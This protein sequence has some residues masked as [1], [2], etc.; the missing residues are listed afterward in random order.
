MDHIQLM[1]NK[2]EMDWDTL[3][4]LKCE[5]SEHSVV[6]QEWRHVRIMFEATAMCN[7]LQQCTKAVERWDQRRGLFASGLTLIINEKHRLV[8][9][10]RHTIEKNKTNECGPQWDSLEAA[11]VPP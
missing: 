5:A 10:C 2:Y 4:R 3:Y 1:C 8:N 6:D 9:C 11:R 7:M